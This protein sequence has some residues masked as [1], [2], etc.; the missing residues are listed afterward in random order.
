MSQRPAHNCPV[1][2]QQALSHPTSYFVGELVE[3]VLGQSSNLR[4]RVDEQHG[5]LTH[6]PLHLHHVF[7]DQV[8]HHQRSCFPHVLRGVPEARDE[9]S[10]H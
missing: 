2:R 3:E 1:P 8:S 6:L 9:I 10:Q 7:Q 5:H 4:G